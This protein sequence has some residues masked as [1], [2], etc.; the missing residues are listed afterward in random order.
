M[1]G[2]FDIKRIITIDMPQ[3]EYVKVFDIES[4]VFV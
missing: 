1:K 4:R 2:T 3:Q